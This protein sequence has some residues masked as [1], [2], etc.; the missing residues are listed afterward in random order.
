M[1][2]LVVLNRHW[3]CLRN[4]MPNAPDGQQLKLTT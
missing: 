3:V 1:R 4:V 2:Q